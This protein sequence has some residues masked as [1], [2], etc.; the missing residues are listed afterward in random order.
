MEGLIKALHLSDSSYPTG[1]LAHSWGLEYAIYSGYVK[2]VR[3][4]YEWCHEAL[5]Y[6]FAPL[7]GRSCNMAYD[8]AVS[9]NVEL[10]FS[11][12]EEVT[13]MRPSENIKL[14]SAQMG[15]SFVKISAASYDDVKIRNFESMINERQSFFCIQH[16]VAW[17]AVLAWL[18]ISKE[19]A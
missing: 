7:E 2:D 8:A 9:G 11:L 19:A 6:S 12:D 17:G 16:P 1:G 4:L 18:G 14:T 5:A 10:L 3:T 13:S 15:R